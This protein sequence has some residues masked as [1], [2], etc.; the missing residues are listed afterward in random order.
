[1][2]QRDASPPSREPEP[3]GG[4]FASFAEQMFAEDE[5]LDATRIA[6]R[7]PGAQPWFLRLPGQRELDLATPV[8]VGRNPVPPGNA[9]E[10]IRFPLEDP[11]RSVSKTHALVE[12]RDGMP[13]ITDLHST[14]GTTVTNRVGEALVCE[15]GTAIPVG[16]G[17]RIGFGE[18]TV[19]VSRRG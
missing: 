1:M 15:P 13:W 3:T 16:D 19:L 12:I 17:W 4:V 18:L 5:D 10:A 7:G 11:A 2:P 6:Q 14:N 9:A 8:V